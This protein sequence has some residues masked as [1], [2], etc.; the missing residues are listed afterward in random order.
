M[1][2]RG[3]RAVLA[4]SVAIVGLV[5][6]GA[7]AHGET[8]RL[9]LDAR[10]PQGKNWDFLR[11]F[12]L[13]LKVHQT[14]IVQAAWA[15]AGAPH[16]ATFISGDADQFRVDNP[17]F[18][19]EGPGG[20]GDDGDVIGN[21][22][23]FGP[24][25]PTC[26]AADNPCV[27][28]GSSVANSGFLFSSPG[29]QPSYFVEVTAPVGDYTVLCVVHVGMQAKL[30]V[31]PDDE[32]IPA[33]HQVAD[34]AANQVKRA[35]RVHGP[36]A[37][38]EAQEVT[39]VGIGGGHKRFTINAGGFVRQVTANV[40]PAA[41]IDMEKGDRLRVLAQPE[42]H[43]ATFPADAIDSVPFITTVCEAVGADS[44]AGSPFDCA[45]PDLFQVV[46]NPEAVTPT[47]KNLLNNPSRF[48]NSGLL[49]GD[50]SYAFEARR[51]GVYT[52]ICLV[53]GSGQTT[54][55]RVG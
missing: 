40:Y 54:T 44:P 31:A 32:I 15:G 39:A 30:T 7:G 9:Q 12:P 28:D 25:D 5:A 33:P 3:I 2:V 19:P 23:V 38:R 50:T 16:T 27:F 36:A 48:V 14:D 52:M 20:L 11:T 18:I 1:S 22:A 10:P 26:G 24:S 49:V 13:A 43:T 55:V 34:T 46:V 35:K 51:N 37:D 6:P 42:I 29:S 17:L 21:P 53:H 8:F 45:S 4:L 47:A 41:G